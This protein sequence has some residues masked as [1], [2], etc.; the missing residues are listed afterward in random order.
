[1]IAVKKDEIRRIEAMLKLLRNSD[2]EINSLLTALGDIGDLIIIGG[3]LRAALQENY[4]LRDVDV[5]LKPVKKY[6]IDQILFNMN[7]IRYSKNRFGGYKV[8][9]KTTTF[10]IWTIHDHW[11]FKEKFYNE[12]VKNIEKT[13]LL[14]YDS[15][16]Y[17]YSKKILYSNNYEKCIKRRII[18]MIGDDE[19]IIN[20]PSPYV[21]IMR[22]LKIK[23]ETG[24]DLSDRSLKY[25]Q[26]YYEICDTNIVN[27]LIKEYEKHYKYLDPLFVNYIVSI[28]N[29]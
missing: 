21:N 20:N 25:I 6:S 23:M 11:G 22:M 24:Y 12:D 1:M 3:A 27:I 26:Y 4:I 19:Y 14:N 10:D 18:D 9:F 17:D 16:V 7:N 29:R 28:F 2:N 15:I 5:I 8:R 13:T